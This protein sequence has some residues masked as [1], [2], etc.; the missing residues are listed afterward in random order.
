MKRLVVFQLI[1]FF[2]LP[3]CLK[4]LD[5][6]GPDPIQSYFGI[7]NFHTESYDLHWDI[8]EE[9]F[10][11]S[12]AY[13]VAL[14]GFVQLT[15]TKGDITFTIKESDSDRVIQSRTFLM[16]QYQYY[17][18]SIMGNE[19]EPY[20]LFQQMDLSKPSTGMIRLGLMHTAMD[21]G[22]VDLYVGGT[23]PDHRVIS[24]IEYAEITDY[25][26]AS[27]EELWEAVIITPM[28]MSPADST[29]LSYSANN[30]FFPDQVY[31]G[32]MG[33][34]TNSSSSSL[35]FHLFNQPSIR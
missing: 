16:E 18:V 9:V 33:H 6:P 24:G 3:G 17:S 30:A 8:N 25:I 7:Y 35:H 19:E 11:S 31:L 1:L 34:S 13:G 20:L 32:V 5:P 2:V 27:E 22:L 28:E 4:N 26:E 23:T 29:I 21:V 15:D 12:H 10:E 14:Q